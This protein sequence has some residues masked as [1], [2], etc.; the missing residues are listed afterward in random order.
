MEIQILQNNFETVYKDYKEYE[1]FFD[2]IKD[3]VQSQRADFERRAVN[4]GESDDVLVSAL[5]DI[6][7]KPMQTAEDLRVLRDRL[8]ATYDAY[9]IVIDFPTAIIEEIN[10]LKRPLQAYRLSNGKQ[11]EIDKEKNDRFKEDVRN[12][13]LELIKG[14]QEKLN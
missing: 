9:K 10:S 6:S 1:A 4:G 14:L 2:S 7:I 12:S 13:H 3:S 5:F 11:I 8:I